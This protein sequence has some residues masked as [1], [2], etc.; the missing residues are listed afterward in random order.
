MSAGAED[1]PPPGITGRAAERGALRELLARSP[2]VTVTGPA[3]VGKSTLARAVLEEAARHHGRPGGFVRVGC[4]EDVA[5]DGVTAALSRAAGLP[6]DTTPQ[7]LAAHC[8]RLGLTV[9]LDDCDPVAGA[10]AWLVRQLLRAGAAAGRARAAGPVLRPGA[11]GPDV[12][13]GY[14]LRIV[15][16][17][18]QPLGVGAERVV[19]VRGWSRPD[20]V[21]AIAR[22]VLAPQVTAPTP[23]V[24]T[25]EQQAPSPKPHVIAPEQQVLGPTPPVIAPEP[26]GTATLMPYVPAATSGPHPSPTP[27]TP[28]DHLVWARL[29]VLSG[30]FD[31]WLA[32]CLGI[33]SD[34]SAQ[35]VEAALERL[36]RASVLVRV[37]NAQT[38][39]RTANPGV[40]GPAA[41]PR[42]RLPAAA[43]AVGLAR[44]RAAG[45]EGVALR[46]FRMAC[47]AL[48][49][50]AQIAWQGPDR[51]IAVQL[52]ETERHNL[53]AALARP[54]LDAADAL[55]A[56]DTAVSLWF[57]WGVCGRRREGRAHLGRLLRHCG[58][59]TAVRARALWL[60][61]WLAAQDHALRTAESLL[62]RAARAAA[63][64]ADADTLARVAHA[65]GVL[66]LRRADTGTA[67][68]WL[69]RAA[70]H[71]YQDPWYGPGP[72]YS[73]V[74]LAIA[75][76]ASGPAGA[77]VPAPR[78]WGMAAAVPL[79]PART[80]Q[81][82]T[83]SGPLPG[84]RCGLG[85]T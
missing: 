69:R 81:N 9:L 29:S 34:V 83:R 3:N 40:P 7:T 21:G 77:P 80:T 50:E 12:S 42:Y 8:A 72:A 26:Y 64:H 32:G 49:A 53:R 38:T 33:S 66:A 73:Q 1:P 23:Q 82:E 35:D 48:A 39:A 68:A 76:A 58:D 75:L 14:G 6:Y 24:I 30:D 46:A 54:P 59:D 5:E 28:T 13:A 78:P 43:R 18:R 84:P 11:A 79:T 27:L 61:G 60:A 17:A 41:P 4:R 31:G 62:D 16:T 85:P 36:L 15:A 2:L 57:R 70:E 63:R 47:A 37:R 56:L 44:V 19:G 22:Q 55:T 51:R 10:C 67:V 74:L 52:V 65:R 20:G 71:T 45:E 25:S